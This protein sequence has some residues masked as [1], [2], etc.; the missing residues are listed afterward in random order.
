MRRGLA[1]AGGAAEVA[2]QRILQSQLDE[3]R[4]TRL[5]ELQNAHAEAM[6]ANQQTFTAGQTDKTIAAT[7]DL[8]EGDRN[9]AVALE[10]DVRQPFAT[11]ERVAKE[12][13]EGGQR[14]EDRKLDSRRLD[15]QARQVNAAVAASNIAVQKGQMEVS[16]LKRVQ[17]LQEQYLNETDPTKRDQI[18]DQIYTLAGKD[19]F[20]PLVGKDAEGNTQFMGAFNTR[21]GKRETGATSASGVDWAQYLSGDKSQPGPTK[22]RAGNISRAMTESVPGV[23]VPL[24]RTTAE[25]ALSRVEQIQRA[26]QT[27][28]LSTQQKSALSLQLQEAM[29]EEGTLG[30]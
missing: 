29:R 26:L 7:K 17:G 14:S 20:T 9:A 5:Q 23:N 22:A 4:Q 28:N 15:I 11:S 12:T 24:P 25:P 10:R 1:E 6:Q 21:T 13:F 3:M 27:P 30:Q 2:G 18:A 16:Q 19:K 8:H